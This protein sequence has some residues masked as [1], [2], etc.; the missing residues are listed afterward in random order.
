[1]RERNEMSIEK[2]CALPMN[3]EEYEN[4]CRGGC[5][6]PLS[7]AITPMKFIVTNKGA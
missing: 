5:L 1:M 6:F 4:I 3:P 7:D 2:L